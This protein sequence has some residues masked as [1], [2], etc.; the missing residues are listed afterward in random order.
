MSTYHTDKYKTTMAKYDHFKKAK[1][2]IKDAIYSETGRTHV[3]W[4]QLCQ[5]LAET[6]KIKDEAE[7]ISRK[8]EDSDFASHLYTGNATAEEFEKIKDDFEEFEGMVEKMSDFTEIA[9]DQLD[10]TVD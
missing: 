1:G 2:P 9:M 8:L 10:I 5:L 3:N 7:D 6:I 4:P